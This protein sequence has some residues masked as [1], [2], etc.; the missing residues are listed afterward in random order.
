[1]TTEDDFHR[2]LDVNPDDHHAR[3]VFADWLQEHDD[4]RAEGY[5]ALGTLQKRPK[6]VGETHMFEDESHLWY[7]K[8]KLH[9]MPSDWFKLINLPE[10]NGMKP[11][12]AVTTPEQKSRR[13]VEDAAAIAFSQ[14]PHARRQELL[15]QQSA[16]KMTRRRFARR[17]YRG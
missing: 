2:H 7:S 3:L 16:E 14:L 12:W 5:R 13:G 8:E 1:V 6:S 9:G 4:P 10:L 11:R 17:K 15:G